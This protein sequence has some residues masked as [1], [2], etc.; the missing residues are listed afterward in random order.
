[1]SRNSREYRALLK[2]T[3]K[4]TRA[5]KNNI[6]SLCADLVA[7]DLI[8]PDQQRALR[9]PNINV[10]ERAADLVQLIADKVEESPV[11]Y[12]TFIKSLEEDRATY[13]D[14]LESLVLPDDPAPSTGTAVQGASKC[15]GTGLTG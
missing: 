8:T 3:G 6:T 15:S 5:V 9:N 13:K 12:H 4:L 2:A 11:N 10:L 1:M 14:V 7:S